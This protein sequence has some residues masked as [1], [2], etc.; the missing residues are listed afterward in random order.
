VSRVLRLVMLC[1]V[2]QILV[3]APARA[4][5]LFA[6]LL[7]L[8]FKGSTT[9]VDLED[10]AG[11]SHWNFGGAATWLGAGPVGIEGLFV[12]TPNFFESGDLPAFES[13]R[14]YALMGNVVLAAPLGWNEYGLRPF[15]SGGL[16]L[17]HAGL[18]T[19]A[20]PRAFPINR[21][22]LAYNF[23]GGAVGFISDHTGLRFDLRYF[24]SLERAEGEG[25]GFGPVRLS[26]WTTSVGV[27]LRY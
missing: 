14:S 15:V 17:L 13:S 3:A 16:G 18:Q 8:T 1:S 19:E 24:T 12:F 21:N 27:V 4:D 25:L 6:P 20:D 5:W 10:G 22:L 7:G 2:L 23:G 26:Y 9:I 11:K